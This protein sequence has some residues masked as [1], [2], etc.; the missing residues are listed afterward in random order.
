M[1]S[2]SFLLLAAALA[3]CNG[4]DPQLPGRAFACDTAEPRCP[5]GY[6]CQDEGMGS[7]VC[8][9]ESGGVVDAPVS[10]FQ[11]AD[12]SALE[13]PG[14]NDT[15]GT[16]FATPIASATRKSISFAGL[17]ICPE[18]DK[19]TYQ[20]NIITA[21]SNLEAVTE[22]PSGMPVSVSIL[23]SGGATL[24]NGTSSGANMLRAY[25]ANLPVGVY[26]VQAY[27]AANVKNNYKVTLTVTP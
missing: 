19:D 20:V 21:M 18:G 23:G 16:A 26:Y 11:C 9:S 10:G 5:D 15:T 7:M 2:L 4:Y 8:F 22:W 13:T 3:A 25:V 27:A 24:N 12:D 14:R 6:S 17:A 1:R